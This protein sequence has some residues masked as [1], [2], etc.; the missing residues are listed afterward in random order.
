MVPEVL[1]DA[2][3]STKARTGSWSGQDLWHRATPDKFLYLTSGV[4]EKDTEA[5]QDPDAVGLVKA[6][7]L[8]NELAKR[9]AFY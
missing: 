8:H 9:Q 7:D 5:G 4:F 6:G 2:G 3:K 1:A